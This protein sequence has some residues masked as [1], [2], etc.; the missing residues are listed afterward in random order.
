MNMNVNWQKTNQPQTMINS[1]EVW[2]LF[3]FCNWT[4]S[5]EYQDIMALDS[6]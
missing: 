1:K 4:D 3:L 6:L 5:A 2:N